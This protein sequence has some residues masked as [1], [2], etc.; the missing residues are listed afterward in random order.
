M[1][2]FNSTTFG[3]KKNEGGALC[4]KNNS[5]MEHDTRTAY[6][7][8]NMYRVASAAVTTDTGLDLSVGYTYDNDLLTAIQTPST[9]YNFAYGAFGLRSNIKVG[10]QTL[11][12]YD[13]TDDGD[14]YLE[15]L[16]YGNSDMVQYTYD[17]QGRVT[18]QTWENGDTV[19]C[20]YDNS[21]AL[22]TVTDSATGRKTT[23]YYDFT[24]R[25]MKYV[26]SGEGYSHSVG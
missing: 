22:A 2:V 4:V 23:Y 17:D 10:T 6:T 18:A 15:K 21:G 5:I 12:S 19:S 7:Y 24:D 8:D 9:T 25:L 14:F 1:F 3:N 20:Q 16:A 11:A 13:Y 26:E